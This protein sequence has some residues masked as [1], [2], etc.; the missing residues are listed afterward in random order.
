MRELDPALRGPCGPHQEQQFSD[1]KTWIKSPA[2]GLYT[3]CPNII[4][5]KLSDPQNWFA[6]PLRTSQSFPGSTL[7]CRELTVTFS[8]HSDPVSL[9]GV[10][11]ICWS[12]M[13]QKLDLFRSTH[14][15]TKP[16]SKLSQGSSWLLGS[17]E[18][19]LFL[20]TCLTKGYCF[21]GKF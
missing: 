4:K 11:L 1:M 10:A 21:P 16:Q 2:G 17:Q 8:V 20:L 5:Y 15:W 9:W 12:M 14:R 3:R 7:L 18:N 13:E 6:F 19:W